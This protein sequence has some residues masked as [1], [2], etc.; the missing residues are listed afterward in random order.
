[1]S[2]PL[3][4]D[5]ASGAATPPPVP[6]PQSQPRAGAAV[7]SQLGSSGG[8]QKIA[9]F[10]RSAD[11][12]PGIADRAQR[13]E[14]D[15]PVVN[16]YNEGFCAGLADGLSQ[17]QEQTRQDDEARTSLELSFT[18]LD[19]DL[20]EK[21]QLRLR[22]TVAAL[23]EAAIA[24]LAMDEDAL[25]RRIALAVAMMQRA[26]DDR[27]IRL[28]PDDMDMVS[29]RLAADWNVKAD[30]ALERGALR[31]ECAN[32]AVEDGPAAWRREISEAIQRC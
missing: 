26:D 12:V 20:A 1:M 29:G 30:P 16:A 15:D 8:F 25:I 28:H 17:T 21:L 24:P 11:A 14:S 7:Y 23:C 10:S 13:S 4:P 31:V 18:K 5:Q 2:D 6:Q 27:V 3:D 19:K 32:G 9:Q 22:D